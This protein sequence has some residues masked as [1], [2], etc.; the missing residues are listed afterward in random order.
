MTEYTHIKDGLDPLV[1]E[2][3]YVLV[4]GSFPS[5]KT[6]ENG[7]H[8]G[9][10]RNRFWPA[11]AGAFGERKPDDGEERRSFCERHHILIW[12]VVRE[13][14]IIGSRDDT[15]RNVTVNRLDRMMETHQIRDLF[16]LGRK[17]EKIYMKEL[18]PITGIKPVLLP[19][20][21]PANRH[22]SLESLTE[23]YKAV[24]KAVEERENPA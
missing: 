8:F 17:A 12:N 20:P 19:S 9:H 7:F 5:P 18:Y 13:C 4:F 6:R 11:L 3:P 2:T 23:K 16:A 21:S 15:I 14:D 10:S 22:E 24:R 1:P